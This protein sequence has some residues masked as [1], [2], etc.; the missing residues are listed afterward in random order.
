MKRAY[1]ITMSALRTQAASS[2][3]RPG[4]RAGRR[5]C[6]PC[7]A[8]YRARTDE[9]RHLSPRLPPPRGEPSAVGPLEALEH[10]VVLEVGRREQPTAQLRGG[11]DGR[12]AVSMPG[13]L[14]RQDRPSS[15]ARIAMRS[16]TGAQSIS[17]SSAAAARRS[18]ERSP[19]RRL[20]RV[21]SEQSGTPSRPVRK[22]AAA[23]SPRSTSISTAA[24]RSRVN[25]R[26]PSPQSPPRPVRVVGPHRIDIL[27]AGRQTGRDSCRLSHRSAKPD[28]PGVLGRL[29]L[30]IGIDR[31]SDHSLHRHS[32]TRCDARQPLPLALID[33]DLRAAHNV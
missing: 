27:R 23:S 2:W 12:S 9:S 10:R 28:Q 11:C 17:L 18:A 8:R 33:V 1:R 15:P 19:R 7:I 32:G 20:H 5:A 14:S 21:I 26:P 30:E 3:T 6:P 25:R 24:S 22:L 31:G 16:S 4:H 13:W 29:P